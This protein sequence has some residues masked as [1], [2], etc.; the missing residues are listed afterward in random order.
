V[1][2]VEERKLLAQ[3]E[4]KKEAE[5]EERLT[6]KIEEDNKRMRQLTRHAEAEILHVISV[7]RHSANNKR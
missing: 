5:E 1:I 7:G 6:K 3:K 4:K 2:Q